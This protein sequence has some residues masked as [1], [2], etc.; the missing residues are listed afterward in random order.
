[1]RYRRARW[2]VARAKEIILDYFLRS[3]LLRD[4][5]KGEDGGEDNEGRRTHGTQYD[6]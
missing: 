6:A 3:T 5:G 2:R 4:A 1:M